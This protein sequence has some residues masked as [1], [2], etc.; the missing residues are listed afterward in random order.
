M[1]K[2]VEATRQEI[3]STRLFLTEITHKLSSN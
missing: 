3:D 1:R 2:E